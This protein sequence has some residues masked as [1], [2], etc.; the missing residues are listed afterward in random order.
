M[1]PVSMR[2]ELSAE[3]SESYRL[4]S[5]V[6]AAHTGDGRTYLAT[7]T[8]AQS[9][10]RLDATARAAIHRLAER[11]WTSQEL[12]PQIRAA[13]G[14][15]RARAVGALLESLRS[16]GWLTITTMSGDRPLYTL[17]P[18][19]AVPPNGVVAGHDG[20]ELVLSRFATLRRDDAD[21]VVESPCAWCDVRLHD[22]ALLTALGSLAG[23]GD[24]AALPE[25]LPASV[26]ARLLTD[27]RWAGLTVTVDDGE[28]TRL[29]TRQW[30]PHEL[31]FHERSRINEVRFADG[32]GK[33][34]WAKGRFAP[35]PA[36]PDP[37][38]GDSV[39]LVRPDLDGCRATDPPM[40]VVIE[41]RRSIR[42]HDDRRPLTIEQLGEFLYRCAGART[43]EGVDSTARPYPAGGALYELEIYPVVRLVTGLDSGMYH[44]D[45]HEHR[46]QRV[47]NETAAVRRLRAHA[48]HCSVMIG[49][50]QLLLVLAAR[51]DRIM[52]T[53]EAMAYALIAKNVG[54]VYQT[55]YLVAT[56]MGLA[57]CGL[58]AGS[59][60]DFA[61]AT[62]RDPLVESS[63]G[64][65]MLGTPGA[66]DERLRAEDIS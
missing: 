44:Y 22:P 24:T 15:D 46:L 39:P 14:D 8:H 33:T 58:G 41:G 47:C 38:E 48:A 30:S 28:E 53:Y 23:A 61:A 66:D 4:R 7:L 5:G 43:R 34:M 6:F 59:S 19:R 50:P 65:F 27:L 3:L 64:E 36:R 21:I 54:V 31:W 25:W 29:R 49:Q 42:A 16:G 12:E 26:V 18:I 45:P 17:R 11:S 20:A 35:P 56:A 40:T 57:P 62:G 60:D 13:D 2:A 9:F 37:L 51:F 55:M 1:V 10:G 52:W 32:F 63:V